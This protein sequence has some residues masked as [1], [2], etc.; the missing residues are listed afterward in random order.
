MTQ[1]PDTTFSL[2]HDSA[3]SVFELLDGDQVIGELNYQEANLAS[4]A[5]AWNLIHTG[6]RPEYRNQGLAAE[7]VRFTMDAAA[8]AGFKVIPT[9]PYIRV[10]L[11]KNSDYQHLTR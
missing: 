4:G 10:W 2:R 11:R 7:L 1:I 9:C 6:V 8:E 3:G 5:P